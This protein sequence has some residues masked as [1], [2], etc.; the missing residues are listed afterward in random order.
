MKK[1]ASKFLAFTMIL[2]AVSKILRLV[3]R[4]IHPLSDYFIGGF[5][6]IVVILLILSS[7]IMRFARGGKHE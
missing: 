5:L 2:Y 3:N 4:Y 1:F 6:L 7:I